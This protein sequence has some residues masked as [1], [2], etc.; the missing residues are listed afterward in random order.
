MNILNLAI[1]FTSYAH[2][3][4][5]RE[6]A[7]EDARMPVL[8]CVAPDFAQEKRMQRVAQARLTSTSRLVVWI[9][10]KVFLDEKGP[11]APIWLQGGPKRSQAAQSSGLHRQRFYDLIS[12]SKSM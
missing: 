3:I 1:R 10:T 7:R 4:A 12:R 2:Y 8:I 11:L 6:R 9:T 5:S